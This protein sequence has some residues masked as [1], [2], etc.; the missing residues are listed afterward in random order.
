MAKLNSGEVD[1][2]VH[3]QLVE[4]IKMKLQGIDDLVVR[5]VRRSANRVAHRLAKEGCDNELCKT[6]FTFSIDAEA[7]VLPLSKKKVVLWMF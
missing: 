7:G 4:S 5:W 1:R 6:W 3:G 2:S